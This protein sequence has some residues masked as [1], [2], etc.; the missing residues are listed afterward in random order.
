M[1]EEPSPE[2][3]SWVLRA[4]PNPFRFATTLRFALVSDGTTRVTVYD[5]AGR[6]VR[7]LHDGWLP[8]GRTEMMWDGRDDAGHAIASG[9]YFVG[10]RTNA[11]T[12]RSKIYRQ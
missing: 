5:V 1:E 6:R 8:S 7:N 10:V 9:V 2:P 3:A 12:M 4:A 11:G